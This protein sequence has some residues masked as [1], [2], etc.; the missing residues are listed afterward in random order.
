MDY[1][2]EFNRVNEISSYTKIP[3]IATNKSVEQHGTFSGSEFE[4][5]NT[6]IEAAKNGFE[7]V[8][9][10]L[11]IQN[12]A[13]LISNLHEHG[14]KVIVSYHDFINTPSLSELNIVLNEMIVLQADICKII[15]TAQN[16]KDNLLILN[17]I[18]EASKKIKI[19]CFAMGEF[20]KHSRLVSPLFGA[21]FTFASL[22]KKRKT[23]E[24]QL[25]LQEM[26]LA[27]ETLGLK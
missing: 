20:G 16:M 14:T 10:D 11:G 4:R 13:K 9:V 2:E 1:L 19:V 6:L 15:T 22:D 5:Q 7:Y 18:S 12:Q 8:D 3:L 27:Y 23:A 24:G 26:N 17:F 21:Y 25:T